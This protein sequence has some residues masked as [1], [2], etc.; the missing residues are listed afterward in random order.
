MAAVKDTIMSHLTC[1][2]P[3]LRCAAA[4][5][6]GYLAQARRSSS[7]SRSCGARSS[8]SIR[9]RGVAVTVV[10]LAATVVMIIIIIINSSSNSSGSSF[11]VVFAI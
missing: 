8:I 3:I 11:V 10:I 5:A 7:S 1:P 4:S 9:H 6:L 2:E